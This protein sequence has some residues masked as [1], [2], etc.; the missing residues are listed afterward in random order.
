[1]PDKKPLMVRVVIR[2]TEG[3]C[4]IIHDKT[5]DHHEKY[6][7]EWI[8]KTAWWALHNGKSVLTYPV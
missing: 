8:S 5:G 3:E 2:E 1:M 4:K 7:R 6:F